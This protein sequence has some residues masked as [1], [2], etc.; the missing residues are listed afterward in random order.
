MSLEYCERD[1]VVLDICG[2]IATALAGLLHSGYHIRKYYLVEIDP[3]VRSIANS[4]IQKLLTRYPHQ[5]SPASVSQ[6]FSLPHDVSHVDASAITSLGPLDLFVASW[7]CQGLSFA[8]PQAKGL[9]DSRSGLLSNILSLLRVAQTV[10]PDLIYLFE[11]V[12]FE[13]HPSKQL[14]EDWAWVTQHL[15][16]PLVFDAALISPAHRV[17]AYWHN[18]G[19]QF[20]PEVDPDATLSS[21]LD[22]EHHVPQICQS[23]DHPSQFQA[24]VV[25]QP[26][27]KF[28]TVVASTHTHSVRKGKALVV[29]YRNGSLEYPYVQ[30]LELMLGLDQGDTDSPG[31][32]WYYRRT[33]I[34]NMV[35]R[36]VYSWFFTQCDLLFHLQEG[37]SPPS[38]NRSR[39]GPPAVLSS[40]QVNMLERVAKQIRLCHPKDTLP[41][42]LPDQAYASNDAAVLKKLLLEWGSG[43]HTRVPVPK[44]RTCMD[45]YDRF[46]DRVQLVR[47]RFR[48]GKQWYVVVNCYGSQQRALVLHVPPVSLKTEADWHAHASLQATFKDDLCSIFSLGKRVHTHRLADYG[49]APQDVQNVARG[50]AFNLLY[51]PPRFHGRNYP[52]LEGDNHARSVADLERLAGRYLEGPLHYT[53]WLTTPMGGVYIPETDKFRLVL[54][55]TRSGLNIATA[56][57]TAKYDM[58]EDVIHCITPGCYQSKFDLAD[59]FFHWPIAQPDCDFLGIKHPATGEYYRYRFTVFGASQSPEIQ[60]HWSVI[61]K[62]ILNTYGLKFCKTSRGKNS[63]HFKCDGAFVDDFHNVHAGHLTQEEVLDQFE[64]V[65]K[66]LAD[67]G[68]EEKVKKAILPA[69]LVAYCGVLIDS[70]NMV[71]RITPERR[72]KLLAL[73]QEFLK[74]HRKGTTMDRRE[75]ASLIGKLQFCAT[76]VPAGQAYLTNSYACRDNFVNPAVKQ[77]PARN[78]WSTEVVITSGMLADLRYWQTQLQLDPVRRFYFDVASGG[79]SFWSGL[80]LSPEDHRYVDQ[81]SHLPNGVPVITTD[82]SGVA[83]GAWYMNDRL[84]FPF[85][86]E[87]SGAPWSNWRE[88]KTIYLAVESWAAKFAGCRLL[89]RSDNSSAVSAINKQGSS[90]SRLQPLVKGLIRTCQEFHIDVCACHIAG[91]HNV[92]SD[93]ISRWSLTL[94]HTDLRMQPVLIHSLQLITGIHTADACADPLGVNAQAPVFG[95]VVQ[96]LEWDSHIVWCFPPRHLCQYFLKHYRRARALQPDLSATFVVPWAP[97]S[98]FW[99]LLKGGRVVAVLPAGAALL[100]TPCWEKLAEA[101]DTLVFLQDRRCV[102]LPETLLVVH[103]SAGCRV[104][105]GPL[106]DTYRTLP[107]LSGDPS[108]D[109][110]A[111][112]GL[113]QGFVPEVCRSGITASLPPVVVPWLFTI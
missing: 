92:L 7:P 97:D 9:R 71:V 72:A 40:S 96:T 37:P 84:H 41:S 61:L 4:H 44:V 30:E 50:H 48:G 99:S 76:V 16:E 1:L 109:S 54:D 70:L 11:N 18:M 52:S 93:A 22:L 59:A 31:V 29:N 53:P 113:W 65:R 73:I 56:P 77:Q 17:R 67:L 12:H 38:P 25:G 24:N 47:A 10:N 58:L 103:F 49:V 68:L 13:F 112:S 45:A 23:P 86:P 104:P 55:C 42:V 66:V 91:V 100:D 15:G 63:K 39:T 51:V 88:L 32:P 34:G 64:S 87:F 46:W 95:S 27:V 94:D 105:T 2:G 28:P 35:D 89:V 33:V 26:M 78:Q 5:L 82:A 75:I 106:Q 83:G 21:V 3:R 60:Q 85:P 110:S 111:L 102:P 80:T 57:S 20:P 62:D 81:H 74:N 107:Y 8:N 108:R 69:F 101:A 79:S 14:R 36:R 98:P 6:C 43:V 19:L 90:S